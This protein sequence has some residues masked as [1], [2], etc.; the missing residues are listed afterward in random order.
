MSCD[1]NRALLLVSID[2]WKACLAYELDLQK[3]G[4]CVARDD[5]MA[6]EFQHAAGE[7]VAR[8]SKELIV[9]VSTPASCPNP[10]D[11]RLLVGIDHNRDRSLD[12]EP[13]VVASGTQKLGFVWKGITESGHLCL[14]ATVA[15]HRVRLPID[16]NW[17]HTCELLAIADRPGGLSI[18]RSLPIVF[19][20]RGPTIQNTRIAGAESLLL[21][22]PVL[23]EIQANDHGMSGDASVEGLWSTTGELEFAADAKPIPALARG[24]GRWLLALPTTELLPGPGLILLRAKDRAAN[25]GPTY[26]LS[27]RLLSADELSEQQRSQSSVVSGDAS[28]GPQPLPNMKIRL[29]RHAESESKKSADDKAPEPLL[30]AETTS[31]SIGQFLF[32]QV[33]SGHY[34]IEI[35]GIVRGMRETR[36]QEL[37]VV[38]PQAVPRVHFRLDKRP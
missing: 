4:V 32:G 36:R 34:T 16:A 22:K 27:V 7:I 3:T 21:G 17:H 38:A 24:E 25:W 29:Y 30:V 26:P 18:R 6:L 28:Y 12:G 33:G 8:S 19:D 20:Q 35:A 10:S 1:T 23:L 13:H 37:Q 11:Q 9:E 31:D 14:D 2:G 15:P 5:F